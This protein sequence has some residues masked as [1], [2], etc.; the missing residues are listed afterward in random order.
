MGGKMNTNLAWTL[1][2]AAILLSSCAHVD[3]W[4]SKQFSVGQ[5]SVVQSGPSSAASAPAPAPARPVAQ[6]AVTI[7]VADLGAEGVS[8]SDSA[9][10]ADL[11]RSE[12][13]KNGSF[14]VIEKKSMDT[15]LAEQAFQ[16]TGCTDTECAV[17]L[18]KVLNVKRMVV[19]S[20]GKLLDKYFLNLRVVSVETG[21]VVF[22][23][24]AK[25]STADEMDL[26]VRN[27]VARMAGS[28]ASAQPSSPSPPTRA[29]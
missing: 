29:F 20:F 4:F 24:S 27:I 1:T 14:K 5:R 13:M 26:A 19:G 23:E 15:I 11:V 9:V 22:G 21:E 7:A 3:P 18:G 16:Q 28:P 12:M 8:R 6:D 25:G 10:I 17:K 2:A